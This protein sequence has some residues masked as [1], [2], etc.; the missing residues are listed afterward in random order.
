MVEA[1]YIIEEQGF[2]E[3]NINCGCPGKKSKVGGFGA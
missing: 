2:N 1:A 3:I